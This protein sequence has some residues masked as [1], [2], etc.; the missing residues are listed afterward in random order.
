MSPFRV[1]MDVTLEDV[2]ALD[3]CWERAEVAIIAKSRA[4]WNL[5]DILDLD[6]VS[7]SDRMWV[8][9]CLLCRTGP[10]RDLVL[11]WVRNIDFRV[12][13]IPKPVERRTL[14]YINRYKAWSHASAAESDSP[15][16]LP[17][18]AVKIASWAAKAIGE[19]EEEARQ[20]RDL[21][22]LIEDRKV[23]TFWAELDEG[24]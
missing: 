21:R 5:L 13:S 9:V 11:T 18:F 15:T 19:E 4:S 23:A 6:T 20:V 2:E 17:R 24:V 1:A 22:V 7:A 14:K 16:N 10:G 8:V 3:P 12:Q